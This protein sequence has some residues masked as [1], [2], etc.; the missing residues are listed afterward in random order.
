M[1]SDFFFNLRLYLVKGVHI[2]HP[3]FTVNDIIVVNILGS[4]LVE[5]FQNNDALLLD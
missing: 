4:V 1:E 2:L 5:K 3:T